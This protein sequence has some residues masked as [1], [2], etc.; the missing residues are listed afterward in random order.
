MTDVSALGQAEARAMATACAAQACTPSR[1]ST[2]GG[3]E[4]PAAVGE[5]AHAQAQRFVLGKACRPR[6][7]LWRDRAGACPSRARR[8]RTGAARLRRIERQSSPFLHIADDAGDDGGG[9]TFLKLA[10]R[11]TECRASIRCLRTRR[12]DTAPAPES[13]YRSCTPIDSSLSLAIC[14]SIGSGTA[15]D[16]RA[17]VRSACLTRYSADSAWLAKLISITAA[18]WPSA[19]ARLISRPSPSR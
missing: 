5:S 7:F 13:A 3:G 14:R 16:L 2:I 18:G 8:Q 12:P 11:G 4:A 15:I 10:E 1:V 19:A 17:S 6:H 9:T